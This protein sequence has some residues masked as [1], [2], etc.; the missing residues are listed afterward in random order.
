MD[1]NPEYE[2]MPKNLKN[3]G[4]DEKALS[5]MGKL[6]WVVTEKVHG[7]NFSILYHDRKLFFAKRKDFLAWGDDF[8]GFQA[9]VSQ[10]EDN[11]LLLF[12]QLSLDIEADTYIIYGELFGGRY[13]HPRVSPDPNVEAIQTGVYY[14]PSIA[15]CAFDIAFEREGIK[16]YLDYDSAIRYFEQS[17]LLYVKPL[18]TGK[19]NEVLDFNLRINS[20][21]P[22]ALGLPPLDNNLIEGVVIKPL[23]H[24]SLR[25]TDLRPIIKLKNPE[26][27][28]D[29]KFHEAEKWSFIPK[30]STRTEQLSFL[31][32]A[33]APYINANRI[34]SAIS[35]IGRPDPA[36]E[37]RQ[38]A[39]SKEILDDVC[40]DFDI[41]NDQM[42]AELEV[43]NY[44][45]IRQRLTVLIRDGMQQHG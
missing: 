7:A 16:Q 41:D 2:K 39:I 21:I 27:D 31:V 17:G 11:V 43:E 1:K 38:A 22:P 4:L 12:E 18:F 5:E 37:Q 26:F 25:H 45:W 6:K 32:E 20:T 40:D 13:P 29:N 23:A 34:N 10:I 28:E 44:N 24:S 14:S 8:F 9:V 15:F 33:M 30:V 19:L 35:K 42:L 3:L 36:N